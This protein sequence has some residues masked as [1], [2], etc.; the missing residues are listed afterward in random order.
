M[1]ARKAKKE[2]LP[3]TI[4]ATG[5]TYNDKFLA[6]LAEITGGRREHISDPSG[7]IDIFKEEM[8]VLGDIAI[9]NMEANL[10]AEKNT[11]FREVSK[12]I[13]HITPSKYIRPGICIYVSR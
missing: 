13:P 12:V 8:G 10:T 5:T 1:L 7:A 3:F 6:E 11:I 4:F 2:K 9:T